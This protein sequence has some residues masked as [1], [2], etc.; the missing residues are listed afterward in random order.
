MSV[1]CSA[2]RSLESHV[3]GERWRA[4]KGGESR[5][6]ARRRA[7]KGGQRKAP[8]CERQTAQGAGLREWHVFAEKNVL[9]TFSTLCGPTHILDTSF[10]F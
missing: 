7:A 9:T 3:G 6:S 4:A 10:K 8:G 1:A 2:L 5:G